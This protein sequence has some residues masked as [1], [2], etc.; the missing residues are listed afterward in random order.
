MNDSAGT[1]ADFIA[2]VARPRDHVTLQ[3]RP[4]SQTSGAGGLWSLIV[5]REDGTLLDVSAPSFA[6]LVR[7]AALAAR[8][9]QEK[10]LR[11]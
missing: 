5:A 2:M 4:R 6:E 9:H 7:R 8:E 11:R 10:E 3:R 1:F